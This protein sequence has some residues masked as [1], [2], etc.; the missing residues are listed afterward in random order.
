M[1]RKTAIIGV[2][3]RVGPSYAEKVNQSAVDKW[4][5]EEWK[6]QLWN[7]EHAVEAYKLSKSVQ[8]GQFVSVGKEDYDMITDTVAK[9]NGLIAPYTEKRVY[10]TDL[11]VSVADVRKANAL[12][13]SLDEIEQAAY[14]KASMTIIAGNSRIVNAVSMLCFAIT[15][16]FWQICGGK[17]TY[18]YWGE[19]YLRWE[20]C[21]R[22]DDIG[23]LRDI[24]RGKVFDIANLAAKGYHMK[25]PFEEH[26][27]LPAEFS[28]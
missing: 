24:L 3:A 17:S 22:E 7:A 6:K 1:H 12:I 21:H 25:Q 16:H 14:D 9:L 28:K 18:M 26:I 5:N 13:D 2:D 20:C 19:E 8:A 23:E 27:T 4:F 11:V 10:E 15:N